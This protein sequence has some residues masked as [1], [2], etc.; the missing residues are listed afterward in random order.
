MAVPATPESGFADGR[1]TGVGSIGA[2]A[3]ELLLHLFSD[4]YERCWTMVTTNLF[5]GEWM[6]VFG[7]R[8]TTALLGRL[9]HHPGIL[10]SQRASYRTWL[11]GDQS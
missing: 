4:C 5:F 8:V 2:G 6:E 9:N 1:R 7:D 11:Q 3:G 10:T